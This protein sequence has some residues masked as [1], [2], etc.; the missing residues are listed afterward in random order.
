MQA[1]SLII[2]S[3]WVTSHL[4]LRN[5]ILDLIHLDLAEPFDFRE[6][7]PRRGV[8]ARNC[9]VAVRLQL[10]DVDRANAMRLDRVNVDDEAVLLHVTVSQMS[11]SR[12][13]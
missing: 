5:R 10:R 13:G 6:T 2:T 3:I 7:S 1:Q 8:Y 9:I 4:A 11:S 12:F